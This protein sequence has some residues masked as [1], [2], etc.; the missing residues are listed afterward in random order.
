[1]LCWKINIAEIHNWNLD[2]YFY[3]IQLN[4]LEESLDSKSSVE[5]FDVSLKPVDYTMNS[6]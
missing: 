5:T 6:H 2:I 4:F 1:M 3:V